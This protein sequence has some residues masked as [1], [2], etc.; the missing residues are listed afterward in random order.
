MTGL[1][2]SAAPPALPD[3]TR[4]RRGKPL[5]Y[6]E[7]WKRVVACFVD[8]AVLSLPGCFGMLLGFTILGALLPNSSDDAV[9]RAF[10]L[11][12][13]LYVFLLY[14][15]STAYFTFFESLPG[16]ATIGKFAVG[17]R[18]TDMDG[19]RPGVA[20]VLARN[21]GKLLS[22]VPL[23]AGFI[24]AAFTAHHQAWHDRIAGCIV[25]NKAD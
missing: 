16:Q 6:A 19:Q 14:V 3:D 18:V 8:V 12:L 22:T 2:Q 20:R 9:E 4:F 23:F 5:A 21:A 1:E 17:I 7:F 24:A 15:M 25:V 10:Q 13:L 11:S